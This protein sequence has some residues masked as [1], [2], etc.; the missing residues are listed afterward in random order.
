MK[1]KIEG[2]EDWTTNGW[3]V[4]AVTQGMAER[5]AKNLKTFRAK[6]DPCYRKKWET[7][8]FESYKLF[9]LINS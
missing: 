9:T 7:I 3:Q 6:I 4:S 5:S 1:Q 2:G 8:L